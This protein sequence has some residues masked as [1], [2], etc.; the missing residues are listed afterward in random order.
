MKQI[1]VFHGPPEIIS[2]ADESNFTREKFNRD[3]LHY[4]VLNNLRL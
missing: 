2:V 1:I 4:L 3:L